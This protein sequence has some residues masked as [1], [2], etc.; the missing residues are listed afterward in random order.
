VTSCK[1]T[2]VL[3][4]IA[5]DMMVHARFL[6]T[7]SL[8]EYV[9]ARKIL[10]SQ[11]AS[12]LTSE[13]LSHV[14]EEIRHA[15]IFKR[16]ALKMS[17]GVLGTYEHAHLLRGDL[18][19]HYFQSIDRA[20]AGIAP[21]AW[22]AYLLTTQLVEER[23]QILYPVY[24]P[25]LAQAGFPGVLAAITKEEDAHLAQT[26]AFLMA[27]SEASEKLPTLRDLEAQLF[28]Q[29]ITALVPS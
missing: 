13:L 4:D 7:L 16:I 2:P 21:D 3:I 19:V 26:Q 29:W 28:N 14:A 8:L 5:A 23:A 17:G 10:K 25:I 24:E 1:L 9:G 12:S 20:V 18:A 15:Q 11:Q 22:Y 27:S 6:N